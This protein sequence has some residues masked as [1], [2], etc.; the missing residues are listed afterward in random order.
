MVAEQAFLAPRDPVDGSAVAAATMRRTSSGSDLSHTHIN[1]NSNGATPYVYMAATNGP[2]SP[3]GKAS[4]DDPSIFRQHCGGATMRQL[5][6][7]NAQAY[8]FPPGFELVV[9]DGFVTAH[10]STRC[11]HPRSVRSQLSITR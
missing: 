10:A 2:H 6:C 9:A 5:H 1:G 8:S 3:L 4:E 11:T 7:S